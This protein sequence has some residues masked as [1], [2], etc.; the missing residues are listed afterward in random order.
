VVKVHVRYAFENAKARA[1]ARL[2]GTEILHK[3]SGS[4]GAYGGPT[5]LR[6]WMVRAGVW[7]TP[8]KMQIDKVVSANPAIIDLEMGLP[9]SG[10]GRS[11]L[12][13]DLV[14]LETEGQ[15]VRVVFWEAKR[16]SDG[17]LRSRSPRPKVM[18]QIDAYRT[19]FADPDNRRMV[20][21]AYRETCIAMRRFC[22]MAAP[23]SGKLNLDPLIL[24]VAENARLEID[25]TP[26]LVIFGSQKEFT[27]PAWV[28]H[29]DKLVKHRVRL[30]KLGSDAYGLSAS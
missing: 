12:R 21:E 18:D 8:E 7:E 4:A 6:K 2:I 26:R 24:S 19:Y 20:A 17:R 16:A 28:K 25:R 27:A 3:A 29:E 9:A 10:D 11:A 14:A 1:Y 13:V 22:D 23:T 30:M 15:A 5:T